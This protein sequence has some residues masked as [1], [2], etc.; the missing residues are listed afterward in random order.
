MA[1]RCADRDP[2]AAAL[3]CGPDR[4]PDVSGRRDTSPFPGEGHCVDIRSSPDLTSGGDL[5]KGHPN[6]QTSTRGRRCSE[7]GEGCRVARNATLQA[8]CQRR[9]GGLAQARSGDIVAT[10]SAQ[11]VPVVHRRSSP[12]PGAG[13]GTSCPEV[14]CGVLGRNASAQ[15]AWTPGHGSRTTAAQRPSGPV[16]GIGNF[17]FPRHLGTWA[18]GGIRARPAPAGTHPP[19]TER[20]CAAGRATCA[21]HPTHAAYPTYLFCDVGADPEG[22]GVATPHPPARRSVVGQGAALTHGDTPGGS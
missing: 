12:S 2:L 6:Y 1:A 5:S 20:V 13:R 14:R 22:A 16:S 15:S 17:D 3:A 9:V 11:A 21:T 18:A 10:R 8:G 19:Y 4:L 7:P